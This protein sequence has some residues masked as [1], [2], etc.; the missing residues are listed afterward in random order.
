MTSE[1]GSSR[2]PEQWYRRLVNLYPAAFRERHAEEM[3]R[4]F[5]K[6]WKRLGE[7]GPA[8]QRRYAQ[9]V[10]WDALRSLPREYWAAASKGQRRVACLA[11][12]PIL[13]AA[14]GAALDHS[15]RPA[16]PGSRP[17]EF[18]MCVGGLVGANAAFWLLLNGVKARTALFLPVA[19]GSAGMILAG[20]A[21]PVLL[22]A[23]QI[24]LLGACVFG[25]L[26]LIWAKGDP[27]LWFERAH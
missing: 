1:T 19:S 4:N 14:A 25:Q 11:V 7:R 24:L 21:T 26:R 3:V 17:V 22:A 9:H 2:S 27:R 10:A 12:L 8:A 5:D 18:F 15:S 13:L 16:G 6:D 23:A 20:A